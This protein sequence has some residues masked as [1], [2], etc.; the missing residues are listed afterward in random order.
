[1]IGENPTEKK[2]CLGSALCT[3]QVNR[4]GTLM[5]RREQI[6]WMFCHRL[7][8]FSEIKMLSEKHQNFH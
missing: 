2:M 8:V 7:Y 1:M 3:G 5:E 6:A 4:V